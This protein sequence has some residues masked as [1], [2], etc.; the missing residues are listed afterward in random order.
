[1]ATQKE[2]QNYINSQKMKY[3]EIKGRKSIAYSKLIQHPFFVQQ[4][5]FNAEDSKLNSDTGVIISH[6]MG[7]G[8]GTV[9]P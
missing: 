3:L 8:K 1:M 6:W 7:G 5:T 2:D 4:R 9:C